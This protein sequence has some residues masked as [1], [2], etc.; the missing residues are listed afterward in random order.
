MKLTQIELFDIQTDDRMTKLRNWMWNQLCFNPSWY[1]NIKQIQ[2]IANEFK[3][4]DGRVF[5]VYKE[6][7]SSKR[8]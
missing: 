3:V 8:K 6:I 4:I 2:E 5:E 1:P 7:K